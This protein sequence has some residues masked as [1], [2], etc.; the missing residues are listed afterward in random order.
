MQPAISPLQRIK[1]PL[2]I[3]I[4][5][6]IWFASLLLVVTTASA[7]T[8]NWGPFRLNLGASASATYTDNKDASERNPQSEITFE[9]GPTVTG[10]IQLTP[11]LP[12]FEP[13]TLDVAASYSI[14]YSL[15]DE[16]D[17]SFDAPINVAFRLPM[18]IMKWD[19]ILSDTFSFSN[20]PLE[21]TFAFNRDD[22][23][24]YENVAQLS[25]S[26]T[27][28]RLGI[29]FGVSRQDQWYP[30]DPEQDETAYQFSITPAYYFR[31]NYSIFWRNSYGITDR[32][33][34]GEP[35]SEGYSS[36][37]G[38]SGQITP[39]L[40]G[41][42]SIGFAHTDVHRTN[43]TDR[44]DGISSTLALNYVQPLRP[45]TTYSIA[46]TRSPGITAAL[47]DSD[48]T[49][50]TS[51][52]LSIAHR[53]SRFITLSPTIGWTLLEDI[54]SDGD[55]EKVHI[56]QIGMG[57]SRQFTRKLSGG[58]TYRYQTR[59]SNLPDQSYDVNEVTVNLTYTF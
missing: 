23:P 10:G 50:V 35:D 24:S 56:I 45:N 41:V 8:I 36:E 32:H 31:E 40:S 20:E 55:G 13:L 58:L 39:N 19:V 27:G 29:N 47:E 57:L 46:F 22:V 37:I 4:P 49:E 52:T 1:V 12:A 6:T 18:R 51:V 15:E 48:I 33:G 59:D 5:P 43:G 26:R 54:S 30:D 34:P 38:V 44:V 11:Q 16:W 3:H 25:I 17:E 14:S 53:L 42:V 9:V 21:Q 28:G 2:S 7:Q